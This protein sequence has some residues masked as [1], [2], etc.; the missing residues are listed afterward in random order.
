[1]RRNTQKKEN[2]QRETDVENQNNLIRTLSIWHCSSAE[3]IRSKHSGA[4]AP[5][6]N[7]N[8]IIFNIACESV[9]CIIFDLPH[10]GQ[11]RS[12]A[13]RWK[14]NETI[15]APGENVIKSLRYRSALS[16]FHLISEWRLRYLPMTLQN[17]ICVHTIKSII[18]LQWFI[19]YFQSLLIAHNIPMLRSC[20]LDCRFKCFFSL[21]VR[22][23]NLES[24]TNKIWW[25]WILM[26][27]ITTFHVFLFSFLARMNALTYR[28]LLRRFHL[29]VSDSLK[30]LHNAFY[31][32][33]TY[34]KHHG[35]INMNAFADK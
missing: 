23:S 28:W 15:Y 11:A 31:H 21:F 18:R 27:K 20:V 8:W 29:V 12:T 4:N 7:P 14:W 30:A 1:M 13:I 32:M 33:I 10:L 22:T 35:L 9:E 6:T 26:N 25:W 2:T 24:S 19:D 5:T 3:S 16:I 17:E 34:F